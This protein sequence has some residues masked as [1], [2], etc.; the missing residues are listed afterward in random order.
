MG[1]EEGDRRTEALLEKLSES[2]Y[3]PSEE[4]QVRRTGKSSQYLMS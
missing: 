2:S 1:E 4:P 3:N